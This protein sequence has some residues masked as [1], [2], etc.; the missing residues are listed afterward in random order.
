MAIYTGE[1][2]EVD[3]IMIT[4]LFI[5]FLL[6]PECDT[7]RSAEQSKGEWHEVAINQNPAYFVV[8]ICISVEVPEQLVNW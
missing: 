1:H 6:N 8:A 3:E 5:G 7:L 4:S 2:C